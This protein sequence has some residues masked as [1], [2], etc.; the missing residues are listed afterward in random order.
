[1]VGAPLLALL[2]H[3]VVDD[4][5]AVAIHAVQH[6]FGNRS[7]GL[8]KTH[9]LHLREGRSKGVAQITANVGGREGLC[10]HVLRVVLTV[11]GGS[12]FSQTMHVE[13]ASVARGLRHSRRYATTQEKAGHTGVLQE[14][15]HKEKKGF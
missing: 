7:T 5:Q 9:A 6:R 4:E 14:S 3:A 1:M 12:G 8:H 15:N 10:R 13:D 11:A 2:A